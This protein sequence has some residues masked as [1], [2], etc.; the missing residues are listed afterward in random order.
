MEQILIVPR[1]YISTYISKKDRS[2]A[3]ENYWKVTIL[4]ITYY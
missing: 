2:I 3:E 4:S 1:Y